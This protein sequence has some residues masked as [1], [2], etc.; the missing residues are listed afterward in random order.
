MNQAKRYFDKFCRDKD[1]HLAISQRPNL[2]II[3]W[4][5]A[6]LA[7]HILPYGQ[8]NFTANLIAFGSL[9]TW[10][11]LEIFDGDSYFRRTLGLVVMV[12]IIYSRL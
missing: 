4:V 2:P 10:A 1:G 8:A 9:F 12:A 7:T 5:V 3:V 11:W 6:W